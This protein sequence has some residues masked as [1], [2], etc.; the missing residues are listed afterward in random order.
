MREEE[1]D[2]RL[3][4]AAAATPANWANVETGGNWV[5]SAATETYVVVC[6]T[7]VANGAAKW[8]TKW[9]EARG[10]RKKKGSEWDEG[11]RKTERERERERKRVE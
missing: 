2:R 1:V 7:T 5:V 4:A 6:F 9:L 11:P 8:P 10:S 3:R